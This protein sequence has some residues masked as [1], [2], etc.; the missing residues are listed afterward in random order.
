MGR[1]AVVTG[2]ASGMGLAVGRHL[3]AHGDRL[4]RTMGEMLGFYDALFPRV[5]EAIAYCDKFTLDEIPA[6][7]QRLLQLLYSLITVSFSVEIWC[8]PRIPVSGVI[9]LECKIAPIQ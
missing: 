2:G 3:V 4:A 9:S 6:E 7:A 5:E 8:Q 1:V